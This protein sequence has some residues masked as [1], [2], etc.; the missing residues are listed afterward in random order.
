MGKTTV[1]FLGLG[2]AMVFAGCVAAPVR[3]AN[4][5]HYPSIDNTPGDVMNRLTEDKTR[6]EM[7]VVFGPPAKKYASTDK[8]EEGCE[9]WEYVGE[10]QQLLLTFSPGTNGTVIG[11]AFGANPAWKAKMRAFHPRPEK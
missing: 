11:S 6:Q 2:I 5:T 7:A 9:V 4:Q 1:A 3:T 10:R 8:S